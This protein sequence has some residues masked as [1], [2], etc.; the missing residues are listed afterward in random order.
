MLGYQS[1]LS[2]ESIDDFPSVALRDLLVVLSS[3]QT[4]VVF[5]H[6]LVVSHALPHRL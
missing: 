5:V 1:V 6:A 2:E 4:Y 3:R